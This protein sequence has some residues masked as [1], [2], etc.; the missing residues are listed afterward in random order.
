MTTAQKSQESPQ[1]SKSQKQPQPQVDAPDIVP[2]LWQEP[3]GLLLQRA[4]SEPHS[5]SMMDGLRL[6]RAL[7][8]RA[9]GQLAQQ[10]EFLLEN[11]MVQAKIDPL[12]SATSFQAILA[13]TGIQTKLT[14]GPVDDPYEREA[15]QV[16]QQV[17]QQINTPAV[18]AQAEPSPPPS[19]IV[20]RQKD[21]EDEALLLAQPVATMQRQT[22]DKT[23]LQRQQQGPIAANGGTITPDIESTIHSTRGSGQQMAEPV[24]SSMETAFGADFSSVRIH[25][26]RSADILNRSL[27][28][29]AFTTGSDIFFRQGE[30]NPGNSAGQE[31]LA[32]EL[33]HVVQ[34]GAA[35]RAMA[36]QREE[37]EAGESD[38]PTPEEKA[39]A[40]AAAA[41]AEAI[42]AAARTTGQQ[43]T[44]ASQAA[45]Q[46]EVAAGEAPQA[47]VA[48]S[49][50]QG[51]VSDEAVTA[52]ETAVQ[53]NALAAVELAAQIQAELAMQTETAVT[54][55]NTTGSPNG[56]AALPQMTGVNGGSSGLEMATQTAQTTV[57]TAF[58]ASENPPDKAPTS[59][60]ED[61]GYEAVITAAETTGTEQR[62]HEPAQSKADQAQAAVE[63]PTSEID[64]HAQTNQVGEMEVA[65]TPGFDAAAF[66]AAL[67]ARIAELTPRTAE[68]AD[69]F[70]ENDTMGNVRADMQGQVTQEQNS[71]TTP[72][73]ETATAPPDTGAVEIRPAVPLQPNDPGSA[74]TTIGAENA[75]P[76]PRGTGEIETPL[77]DSGTALDQQMEDA[78]ITEEQLLNGNEPDFT[79]AVEAKGAAQTAVAET[80]Q[81]FRGEEESLL[82]TA[83][84]EAVSTS[85]AALAGI[86]GERTDALLQVDA[87]QGSTMS[88][89]EQQR[90]QIAAD[91]T[92]IY[93]R[94]KANVDTIL[95]RLDTE[96]MQVFDTGAQEAAQVFE[97]FVDAKMEAYKQHRY[98]GFFGWAK[99]LKD[100]LLG[101]PGEVNTF[102]EEGRQLYLDKMDAVI[103]NVVAVIGT[104]L[105]EAK[106]EVAR[107]K[108]EIQEYVNQ[109]PEDLQAVG[110]EA[111]QA[112]QTRFDQLE[113][114]IDAKQN[115]LID[116]LA[117]KYQES[118]QAIDA[119]IEEMK[120]A[121]RGLIDQ[122]ID[123]LGG[124]IQ[125]I[126]ELKNLLLQV[127][128]SA[129]DAIMTILKDP[130]GFVGNLIAAVGQGLRNFA[131]NILTHLQTGFVEWLTGTMSGA[132]IQ[133]PE[134]IFSLQGV[135]DLVLQILGLT[136][137]NFRARAV[138]IFGEGIVNA[139]ET[140]FEI[141]L[142]LKDEGLIG[143]WEWIQD[144]IATLKDEVI[145]GI[146]T[147]IATEVVEAGI[148]WLIG[149]LG[150][151]A[152]AFI[153]AAK[154]IYDIIMWFINN[155]SQ[156]MTL[157]QSIISSVTAIASGSLDAAA[158]FVENSL[159]NFIPV[160]IG[161]LASLLGLGDLAQKVRSIIDKVQ[162]PV[163][164]A[165]DYVLEMVH[166]FVMKIARMLGFGGE[167]GGSAEGAIGTEVTF[168][169]DE[170]RHT[171]SVGVQGNNATLIV[172][173][174][175]MTVEQR[176]A[177]WNGRLGELP[178]DKQAEAQGLLGQAQGMLGAA[179]ESAD[180]LAEKKE[181]V[182][183]VDDGDQIEQEQNEL[184]GEERSLADILRQL[185][186]VFGD[187]GTASL[188]VGLA[189]IRDEERQYLTNEGT[190]SQEDAETTAQAIMQ[191]YPTVFASITVVDNMDMWGYDYVARMPETPQD[192]AAKLRAA[193]EIPQ[194]YFTSDDLK[195][196]LGVPLRT[197]QYWITEWRKKDYLFEVAST[198]S[199][200]DEDALPINVARRNYP[201]GRFTIAEFYSSSG[202]DGIVSLRTV[203]RWFPDWCQSEG[204]Y[205]ILED[206]TYSFD[207]SEVQEYERGEGE[208]GSKYVNPQTWE[209]FPQYV[210]RVGSSGKARSQIRELFYPKRWHVNVEESVKADA[211]VR[212]DKN[213][214][215][216]YRCQ[217][218]HKEF[219]E[220][221]MDIDHH[222]ESV[223]E[224]WNGPGRNMTQSERISWHNTLENLKYVCQGCN[225]GKLKGE[226]VH[227]VG[228][229]FRGPTDN[230]L[231]P[232]DNE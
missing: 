30:Y 208:H 185:F 222:D 139:L 144:K 167:G 21:D 88:A 158:Q 29:R 148:Q 87:Q 210:R 132:G 38:E 73:T 175:P 159:A 136:W 103:D 170:E 221:Q 98:G 90:A 43:Q 50:A 199:T 179:E 215:R 127:L 135:L 62:E 64:S 20:R 99:W 45:E 178:E 184:E 209:L 211:F 42:A 218:C 69:E 205:L 174:E 86:Y 177:D 213:G 212:E 24:R 105:A 54:T 224:H 161:F 48:N 60:D 156:M 204:L 96:V 173:S 78:E 14:L 150:G 35:D 65:E 70:K 226:Y 166:G 25:T 7:G 74:P 190:I 107:G 52:Q 171:L 33:T 141:F 47:E 2:L 106:A 134:D 11:E 111:A 80:P 76:Q 108:Q 151:P 17:V 217:I 138:G 146:K 203:Q 39:A 198:V 187:E 44:A 117:Q 230:P 79:T 3:L 26:N 200:F 97:D 46:V 67:M 15:D 180:F 36:V 220:D 201:A 123:A 142:V 219:P 83:Q 94:T 140:G 57:S 231:R 130:I 1:A 126:L 59:P 100:K 181:A 128:A 92:A 13:R 194:T 168:S 5:L 93:E 131:T 6:Q 71:A 10:N 72:L 112:V 191:Q 63:I 41:E 229:R 228:K 77:T 176:L 84:N 162:E 109:L 125:T 164:A 101:M 193:R 51:P 145:E 49:V 119:R 155:A 32:H 165:I 9:I 40:E 149:I 113:Q 152:G 214:N 102:Y 22:D 23:P 133:M 104:T 19:L 223:R 56:M 206:K 53:T 147:M 196:H 172:A 192:G 18:Q 183:T 232:E 129:A 110:E 207:P 82:T 124:V 157:V 169:A 120:A 89:D 66:K 154:A 91:I 85:E 186:E 12:A 81:T 189:A 202:L 195:N 121:N 75:A 8:N 61:P 95:A 153:K 34:Q 137:E 225:R 4:G 27:S 188:E 28:A 216:W 16:A 68:A 122:A 58:T 37:G 114:Q 118:V 116:T 182:K 163:N 227:L 115:E 143:L 31:L 55:A 197:A 160:A